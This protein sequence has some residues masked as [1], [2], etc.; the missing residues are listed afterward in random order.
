[1][2]GLSV[3]YVLG[4]MEAGMKEGLIVDLI[5]SR[6][7]HFDLRPGDLDRLLAADAGEALIGVV[8]RNGRRVDSPSWSRPRRLEE[9][10]TSNGTKSSG[11]TTGEEAGQAPPPVERWYGGVYTYVGAPYGYGYW[12]YPYADPYPY[13]SYYYA[14]PYSYR[15]GY[16]Y[17]GGYGYRGAT[18][19]PRGYNAP[20]SGGWHSSPPR[21]SGSAP[22]GGS[23]GGG[24]P[25]SRPPRGSH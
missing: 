1:P 23:S 14:Y 5:R 25:S 9:G 4:L 21:G 6:D 11:A 18:A 7:L 2:D 17:Y 20:R 8:V 24:A 10:A 19:P 3:D 15:Y 13:Y 12:A 16:P 22:R